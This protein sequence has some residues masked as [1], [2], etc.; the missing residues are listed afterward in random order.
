MKAD[1]DKNEENLE[2][3]KPETQEVKSK[4]FYI[5]SVGHSKQVGLNLTSLKQEQEQEV[6]EMMEPEKEAEVE[7][8]R[9]PVTAPALST[10]RSSAAESEAADMK[11]RPKTA[12]APPQQDKQKVGS[13]TRQRHNNIEPGL[14]QS[15]ADCR[16]YCRYVALHLQIAMDPMRAL[17]SL[18]FVSARGLETSDGGPRLLSNHVRRSF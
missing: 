6:E 9:R 5:L 14:N 17:A 18:E 3:D 4:I 10:H 1:C 16:L 8:A 11:K 15:A 12:P 7:S 2:Q 13:L